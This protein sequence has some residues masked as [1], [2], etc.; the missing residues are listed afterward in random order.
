MSV[1][2]KPN[3]VQE[4]KEPPMFR[5][6]DGNW[7]LKNEAN[8]AKYGEVHPDRAELSC[9]RKCMAMGTTVVNGVRANN[10]LFKDGSSCHFFREEKVA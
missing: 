10:Y 6:H 3:L 7:H 8:F 4:E 2:W 9:R 5:G 1:H